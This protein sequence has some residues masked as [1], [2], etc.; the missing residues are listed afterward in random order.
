MLFRMYRSYKNQLMLSEWLVEVPRD[1]ADN[2]I[3]ILCPEV[4]NRGGVS[5]H[6]SIRFLVDN[7]VH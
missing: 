2:W 6:K 7:S 3:L 1:I 4:G 5:L